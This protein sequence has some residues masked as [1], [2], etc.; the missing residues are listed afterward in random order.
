M[1]NLQVPE[2]ISRRQQNQLLAEQDFQLFYDV[3]PPTQS[4]ALF[5]HL[6]QHLPWQQ[7]QIQIYGRSCF[8]PRLQVWMGDVSYRYSNTLFEPEVWLPELKAIAQALSK[9]FAVEFNSVLINLYRD[10]ADSMG[11][12]SDDEPELGINPVIASLSLGATRPLLIR[13]KGRTKQLLRIELPDNSLLVMAGQCQHKFQH[14]IAKSA[15]TLPP[16]I[17]LTFRQI[18]R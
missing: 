17:N 3:L 8:V 2:I 15:R 6:L 18:C 11:Y 4:N 9:A 12:H 16:R 13:E 7:P 1:L 10:G 14:A 5:L